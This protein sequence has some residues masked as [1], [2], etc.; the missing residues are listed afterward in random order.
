MRYISTI[1]AYC[2]CVMIWSSG[3]VQAQVKFASK[4]HT[5]SVVLT[6]LLAG[7]AEHEGLNPEHLQQLGG[8]RVIWEA[9]LRGEID[10]YVDYTGTLTRSILGENQDLTLEALRGKLRAQGVEMTDPLGFENSYAIGVSAEFAAKTNVSAISDLAAY[11]DMRFGFSLPFT[12]RADGWPSLRNRYGLGQT[13]QTV[14]HELGYRGLASG[15]LD[16]MD[17]YT[18][19]PEIGRFQVRVLVDDL[20]YFPNYDAVIV[21]RSDLKTRYPGLVAAFDQLVGRI[22]VTA[23]QRMNEAASLDVLGASKVAAEFLKSELGLSVSLARESRTDIIVRAVW[24]HMGLVAIS[25]VL[26]VITAIPLGIM[27]SLMPRF[28]P[29][30]LGVT[31]VAQTLPSLALFVFMIPLLGIGAEPAIAALFIYSLLP[32][33]RNT[34]TGLIGLPGDVVRSADALGLPTWSRLMRIDLPLARPMIL[35]GIKTAAVINVGT[36]TLGA[37][38]GAG[39]LGEPI[40]I[41]IRLADTGLILAGAVPAALMA[42]GV[43]G[44]FTGLE[45]LLTPVG[46]RS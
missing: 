25:L 17:V 18:T 27:A 19:D 46:L 4:Q 42:L 40:L 34:Y 11:P 37:L 29:I 24:E 30:I 41:G 22:D 2:L 1:L 15:Q 5:E 28:G 44:L 21:Y 23:M 35:A 6:E 36:A 13:P 7:L 43:Q 26:A 39:G 33:V 20:N 10:A 14:D 8:T 32:V 9:M 3:G 16:G 45:R 12:D 38:I 31:A